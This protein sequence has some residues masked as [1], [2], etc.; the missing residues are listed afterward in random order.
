MFTTVDESYRAF[1]LGK[2]YMMPVSPW[3]FTNMPGFR[4]NWLWRG[5]SLWFDRWQQIVS[6]EAAHQPE[7][8]QIIT[9]NDWGECKSPNSF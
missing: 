1:L 9:W 5:D 6:M 8:L 7:Y 4:K 2:T 3:F